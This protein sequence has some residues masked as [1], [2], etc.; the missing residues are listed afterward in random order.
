MI[1]KEILNQALYQRELAKYNQNLNG[2]KVVI[3]KFIAPDKFGKDNLKYLLR[4]IFFD[5]AM[6]KNELLTMHMKLNNTVIKPPPA[7]LNLQD[8]E[9][10]ITEEDIDSN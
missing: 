7:A 9:L 5:G 8:V 2:Y 10:E 4:A 1:A 3:A 6:Q